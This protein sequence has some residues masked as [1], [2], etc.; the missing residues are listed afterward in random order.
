MPAWLY[1]LF[2]R[3]F[4]TRTGIHFAENALKSRKGKTT[5]TVRAGREFL[6]IPG[7]TTMPDAVLQ[8]MHRPALDI[9]SDEMVQLTEGLLGDL[10]KLFATRGQS[11]IYISNG[12]GAWEAT[13]SNVR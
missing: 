10:S 11:Y 13:R 6:A 3:V 7:P 8:A 5:M 9:Y 12:H 4:F 1:P 2:L